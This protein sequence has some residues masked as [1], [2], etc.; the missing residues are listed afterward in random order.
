MKKNMFPLI[1]MLIGIGVV[2]FGIMDSGGNVMMF[3]SV[4]SLLIVLG[5]SFAALAV[6]YPL[7]YIKNLPKILGAVMSEPNYNLADLIILLEDLSQKS[8]KGGVLSLESE[9]DQIED[10]F[11]KKG[12]QLVIDGS[13]ADEVKQILTTEIDAIEMRHETNQSI[14]SKWGALAPG[15]GMIGTVIGLIVMLGDLST[16]PTALGAGMATALITTFYGSFFAN[17]L[18]EPVAA[19]LAMKTADEVLFKNI[20]I[21]GIVMIQSGANPRLIK[22]SLMTYLPPAE[23]EALMKAE[24]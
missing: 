21:Q 18:F 13:E 23:R 1:A 14:I 3:I 11:L 2:F 8:R 17:L 12:L 6:I 22:D 5:G 16:D 10:P 7:K 15:F 19:N 9:V 24:E 4:S 20:M